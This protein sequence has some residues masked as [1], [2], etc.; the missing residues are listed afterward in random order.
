MAVL[1]S[2]TPVA[3]AY[4]NLFNSRGKSIARINCTQD[5]GVMAVQGHGQVMQQLKIAVVYG[6]EDRGPGELHE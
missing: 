4:H 1:A 3:D 5:A 2:G 6:T